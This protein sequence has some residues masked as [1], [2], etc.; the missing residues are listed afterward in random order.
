M[1]NKLIEFFKRPKEEIGAKP[2]EGV[3][4]NCWGQ[5]EYAGRIR[6]MF[7]DKQIDVNNLQ[8]S[9]AFIQEF[10]IKHIDGI[11]LIKG[12]NGLECPTC[13]LEL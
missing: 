1:I 3:C 2:P 9:H 7:K 4:P 10:V 5:Q 11:R 12:N 8:A 6:E 13:K